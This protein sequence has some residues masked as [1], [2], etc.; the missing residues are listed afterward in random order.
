MTATALQAC[1][2]QL[3]L[4]LGPGRV[5]LD[6]PL[7]PL[8]TF[9]VGGTADLLVEARTEDE[10]AAVVRT[11]RDTGLSVTALGGGS[12]VLVGD[13]GVR[14][15]VVLVRDRTIGREDA[16]GVRAG[17]GLTINGLVRW[18]VGQGLAEIGRASCRERV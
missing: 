3:E 11:A 1:T 9:K 17:A 12:N 7:A 8:T 6:A 4:R 18:L 16:T 10:L 13:G 15:V 14:G 2:S 5:T